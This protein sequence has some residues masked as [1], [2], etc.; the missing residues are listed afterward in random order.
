MSQQPNPDITGPV[1][2]KYVAHIE[3]NIITGGT[4]PF[5][6]QRRYDPWF[7]SG[8]TV[9]MSFMI[10]NN[11]GATV[12]CQS[13]IMP[14]GI[15]GTA[16]TNGTGYTIQAAAGWV[17]YET[18]V[19][20][21]VYQNSAISTPASNWIICPLHVPGIGASVDIEIADI[22]IEFG[23]T[24]VNFTPKSYQDELDVSLPLYQF[25]GEGKTAGFVGDVIA[26][27]GY[28]AHVPFQQKLRFI[29]TIIV[30]HLINVGAGFSG[31]GVGTVDHITEE[32]YNETRTAVAFGS[33]SQF[34]STW[35][36]DSET[37]GTGI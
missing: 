17:Q 7:L 23:T 21:P 11:S 8:K 18:T 36:A 33:G 19:V 28:L 25:G 24:A 20:F 5:L 37:L 9:T 12:S 34:F 13:R 29:P 3:M 4:N 22:S 27:P 16:K 14:D 32:G 6:A 30:T 1:L 26:G 2:S 10:N 35:T 15:A 31:T